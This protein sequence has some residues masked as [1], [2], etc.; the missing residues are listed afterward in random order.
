ML[1]IRPEKPPLREFPNLKNSVV[2]SS[3]ESS[4]V[5][6]SALN[7]SFGLDAKFA[8]AENNR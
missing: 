4:M 2:M 3:K 7:T 1:M 5:R 8:S 6:K